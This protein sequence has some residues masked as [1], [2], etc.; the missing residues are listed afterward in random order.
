MYITS[1]LQCDDLLR[2]RAE[3]RERIGKGW[4]RKR[5]GN[6]YRTDRKRMIILFLSVCYFFSYPFLVLFYSFS[7]RLLS[8]F[9]PF[10]IICVPISSFYPFAL[11]SR[12][13]PQDVRKERRDDV[14]YRDALAT[15]IAWIICV[16]PLHLWIRLL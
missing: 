7:I 16:Y 5:K 4:D 3:N 11:L 14:V 13:S 9:N 12:L 2:G 1:S 10:H 6:G 8:F 15:K